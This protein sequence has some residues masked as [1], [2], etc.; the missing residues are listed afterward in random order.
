M[1]GVVGGLPLTFGARRA[2]IVAG[3]V[4]MEELR[5]RDKSGSDSPGVLVRAVAAPWSLRSP[6]PPRADDAEIDRQASWRRSYTKAI[7]LS[8]RKPTTRFASVFAE[9]H[10]RDRGNGGGVPSISE[11]DRD[12]VQCWLCLSDILNACEVG[13][14]GRI[15]WAA[16]RHYRG[17]RVLNE[18]VPVAKVNLDARVPGITSAQRNAEAVVVG[19][20]ELPD[21]VA[22]G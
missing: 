4:S 20:Q 12:N 6:S 10:S 8:L 15:E 3:G 7:D 5:E 18:V 9:D 19:D 16:R 1:F 11:A 14:A 2:G 22:E 21:T 13:I 17:R